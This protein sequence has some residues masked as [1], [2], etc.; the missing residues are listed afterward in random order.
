[1]CHCIGVCEYALENISDLSCRDSHFQMARTMVIRSEALLLLLRVMTAT[2][3]ILN[4]SNSSVKRDSVSIFAPMQITAINAAVRP[5]YTIAWS[6]GKRM[7]TQKDYMALTVY[8]RC[9]KDESQQL[10]RASSRFLRFGVLCC[11]S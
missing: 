5:C 2:A 10:A 9:R 1:M 4:V 11:R 6:T 7:E 3:R 8:G